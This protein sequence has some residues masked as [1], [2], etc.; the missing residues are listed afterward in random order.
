MR[1]MPKEKDQMLEKGR[2]IIGMRRDP[3]LKV[4]K[5]Q[6][7]KGMES[8]ITGFA[9]MLDYPKWRRIILISTIVNRGRCPHEGSNRTRASVY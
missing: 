9:P 5:V 6:S 7:R 8:M 2:Q 4:M 3:G 1:S